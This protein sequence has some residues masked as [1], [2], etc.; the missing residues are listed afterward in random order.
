MPQSIPHE[1]SP[2]RLL[3]NWLPKRDFPRLSVKKKDFLYNKSFVVM[4][5]SVRSKYTDIGVVPF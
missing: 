2:I 5:R 1:N 4:T 3:S